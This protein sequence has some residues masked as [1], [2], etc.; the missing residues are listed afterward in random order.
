MQIFLLDQS[1][2]QFKKHSQIRVL[3]E[4]QFLLVIEKEKVKLFPWT[5]IK[6]ADIPANLISDMSSVGLTD[7]KKIR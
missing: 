3:F 7:L 6:Y 5:S 4:P 1:V 2:I